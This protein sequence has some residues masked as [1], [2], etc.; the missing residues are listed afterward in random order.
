MPPLLTYYHEPESI[1]DMEW[2]IV[3]RLLQPFEIETEMIKEIVKACQEIKTELLGEL[4]D[5]LLESK[6]ML[7]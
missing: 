7:I 6:E 4:H 3:G 1:A 5:P 2:Q